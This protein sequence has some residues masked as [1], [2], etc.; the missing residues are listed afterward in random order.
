MDEG[1]FESIC[2]KLLSRAE[3]LRSIKKHEYTGDLDRLSNFRTAAVIQKIEVEHAIAGMM[4]KHT[5]SIYDM[6]DNLPDEVDLTLWEEKIMDHI[7]YLLL[8]FAA[9]TERK[10]N[11]C[12]G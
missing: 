11:E 3:T 7:N 10:E 5:V 6:I 8:L 1:K 2:S 9:V 4:A 12:L